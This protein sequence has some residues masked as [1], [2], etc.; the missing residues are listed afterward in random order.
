MQRII[1]LSPMLR[2]CNANQFDFIIIEEIQQD[3]T[4]H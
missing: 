4:S 2:G 1:T 3:E